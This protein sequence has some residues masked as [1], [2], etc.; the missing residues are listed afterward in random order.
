MPS[1][2][3]FITLFRREPGADVFKLAQIKGLGQPVQPWLQPLAPVRLGTTLYR[4]KLLLVRDDE[5]PVQAFCSR[6]F[7]ERSLMQTER[8]RAIVHGLPW[9]PE[10]LGPAG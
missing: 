9:G 6:I 7:Q 8:S 10:P 2:E 1:L 5:L 3:Q 4:R